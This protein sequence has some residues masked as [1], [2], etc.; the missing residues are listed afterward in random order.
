MLFACIAVSVGAQTT[1][2]QAEKEALRGLLNNYMQS[3]SLGDRALAR[4][5]WADAEEVS[6]INS[7]GHFFGFESIYND[8]MVASFGNL[9]E[10]KL[11]SVSEIINVYGDMGYIQFYWVFDIKTPDGKAEQRRGRETLICRKI[12]EDWK[13]YHIHYSGMPQAR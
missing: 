3:I 12:G 10:K 7:A 6:L 8:F 9:P 2:D 1:A 11:S 5:V 13:I 4:A